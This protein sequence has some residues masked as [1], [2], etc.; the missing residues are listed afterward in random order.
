MIVVYSKH[1]CPNC[2]TLK[3]RLRAAAKP[4]EELRIDLPENAA[5]RQELLDAG[6]RS[7]PVMKLGDKFMT[8]DEVFGT[9]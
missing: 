4:F 1:P 2:E 7:V 8:A 5:Q 6:Y 3:R 9:N